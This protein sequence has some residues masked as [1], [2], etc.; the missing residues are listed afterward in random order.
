VRA[1]LEKEGGLSRV[2]TGLRREKS[3]DFLMARAT[4]V[5]A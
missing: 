4:L 3:I 2:S 5:Q 1:A